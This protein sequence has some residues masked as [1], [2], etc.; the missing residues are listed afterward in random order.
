M[1]N[2]KGRDHIDYVLVL[3][4]I[5]AGA[6]IGSLRLPSCQAWHENKKNYL[7]IVQ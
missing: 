1:E 7:K 3:A 4:V 6:L 2:N 5:S